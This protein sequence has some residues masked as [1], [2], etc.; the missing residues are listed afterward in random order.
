MRAMTKSPLRL[1]REAL[2][3]G[4]SALPAYSGRFSRHDFTQ[5]QLFAILVLK[6]FLKTDFRGIVAVLSDWP[7]L[8]RTL[9]LKKVPHYSTLCYAQERLLEEGKFQGLL[10]AVWDSARQKRLIDKKPIL[11]IDATGLESRHVSAY[12]VDRKGYRRF[13]RK[14]WPKLT[15]VSHT[16]THL[17]AGVVVGQGPSQDSPQFPYAIRQAATHL[18]PDQ[19]LGDK[20]YDGE[21]NH[22]LCREELGIRSTIIPI[23]KRNRGRKWPTTKYRR[24]MRRRFFKRQY[25]QRWQAESVFSRLKRRL[26]SALTARSASTQKREILLRVLTHDLMILRRIT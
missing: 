15:A 24:Q 7:D 25:G 8:A 4:Q 10:S 5:P 18:H 3:L 2:T 22:R 23:N 12:Y 11:A 6:V 21:H 19:V 1:A 9:G 13:K 14:R 16:T 17:I 20:G 26:G